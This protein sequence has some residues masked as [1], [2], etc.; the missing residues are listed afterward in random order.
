MRFI[1][2]MGM[3]AFILMA[4]EVQGQID[5]T[6]MPQ[7][8]NI[9]FILTDD[10]G[11][12]DVGVFNQNQRKI[13]NDRSAPW[14]STPHLDKMANEGAVLMQHY[15][16]APVC[17]PSR[18][19]LLSGRSQGHTEVRDNQFDK[20]LADNYTLARVMKKAG[21]ATAAIGKW[22]LQGKSSGKGKEDW[23]AVPSKRGFDYFYGYMRHSDGHE[24][25]PKEGVYRG[26][27]EVWNNGKEISD[28]LDKSYTGD[29]WTAVAKH[30][31]TGQVQNKKTGKPFFVYL[32]YD[33]PHAVLELP[34]QAYPKGG[35][36]NGGL[37]YLG[38]PGHMINTA[39][40]KVDSYVHPEYANATYDDDKDPAT[41]EVPWPDTYKRYASS[42]RRIDDGVGDLLQ[43]LK[44][45]H[46]DSNTLV[47]FSS[48]NGPSIASYLPE[49][50]VN[51]SP[52]FFD[53]YGPFDGIKRDLL[54]G[55]E[56]MP[57]IAHWPDHIPAHTVS[58]TPCISYDWLATFTAAAGLPAPANT[59]GVSLLPALTGQG[60]QRDGLVYSEYFHNG[61][62]PGY[63]DFA[64]GNRNRDRKQMQMIR[65]GDTVGIRY[66][67]KS[68]DDD[69]E[70]YDIIKDTHQAHNLAAHDKLGD[71]Q[72]RMKER[73][74]Q[75]RLVNKSARRPYDS[76]PI[77]AVEVKKTAKGLRWNA[78]DGNF[79]WLPQLNA[80][81]A[82]DSGQT[83][84]LEKFD[85]RKHTYYSFKGYLEIPKDGEYI[86]YVTADE[87]A[88]VR[89]HDI[90]IIDADYNYHAGNEKKSSLFLKKGLHPIEI[91]VKN[92]KSQMADFHMEWK[93][94]DFGKKP[95]ST[96]YF[97]T[98]FING[99]P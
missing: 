88:F 74:L 12:G 58:S 32:A 80:L 95:V 25:Y 11:Y 85:Y 84:D 70:I 3:T 87:K 44:D 97:F 86:F 26:K 5:T 53:G 8:P 15:A 35:G 2:Y 40:G 64:S 38:T 99:H 81:T 67:V 52:E 59:D 89:L 9:I 79:P 21:Y 28:N 83:Q 45:L 94:P 39:S 37:R 77:P 61:K 63:N 34:T 4:K 22:G 27:K 90:A 42:V 6:T 78:Y 29:L 54:E 92:V 68:Q 1:Y 56:R 20:A 51:Y 10:L 66:N 93:G 55:G 62:T 19:S 31:I 71:L 14:M 30:W 50:F 69:F 7:R 13:R 76:I 46:I 65:M 24:H 49:Q 41:P 98:D 23:P 96:A 91:S 47:V 36:L 60:E 17:A 72:E 73:V 48:D 75:V 33:T 18:A 57:L 82:V 43:L 16:A